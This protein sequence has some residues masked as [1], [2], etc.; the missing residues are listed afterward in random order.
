MNPELEVQRGV[1]A[2]QIVD[3][4]IY[5]EAITATKAKLFDEWA[6]TKWYQHK[7]RQE[8]WR[9][10]R[11]AESIEAQIQKVMHTGKMGRQTLDNREKLKKVV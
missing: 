1:L 3:N 6:S 5:Q 9:M 7:K 8:I 4:P 2:Q 11:A 10:Y